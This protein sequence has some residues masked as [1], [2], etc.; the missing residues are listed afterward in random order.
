[1]RGDSQVAASGTLGCLLRLLLKLGLTERR[2][3]TRANREQHTNW[4]CAPRRFQTEESW[5]KQPFQVRPKRNL[6]GCVCVCLL[7]SF[8]WHL[9]CKE[10]TALQ[11]FPGFEEVYFLFGDRELQ[12]PFPPS[13]L[14]LKFS[15]VQESSKNC[16]VSTHVSAI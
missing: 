16:I 15:N 12:E 6:R 13:I 11:G 4:A 7:Y 5:W 8:C 2:M 1:M 9:F 10:Q 14:L 3:K